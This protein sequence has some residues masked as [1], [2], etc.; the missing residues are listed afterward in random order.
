MLTLHLNA[1]TENTPRAVVANYKEPN[2]EPTF[3]ESHLSGDWYRVFPV[4]ARDVCFLQMLEHRVDKF[5]PA[6]GGGVLVH[7]RSLTVKKN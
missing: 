2:G 1:T 5:A 6:S 3:G 7:P 4:T